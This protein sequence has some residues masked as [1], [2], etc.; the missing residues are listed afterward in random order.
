MLRDLGPQRE[1]DE[2]QPLPAYPAGAGASIAFASQPEGAT[3]IS[4]GGD[5]VI[6]AAVAF[7]SQAE[8]ATTLAA[9]G[10][11]TH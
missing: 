11:V 6:Y 3:T 4:A 9:T 8:G 1:L 5:I 10:T 2:L 7:S